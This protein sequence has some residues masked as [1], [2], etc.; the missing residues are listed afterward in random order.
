[1]PGWSMVYGLKP[2]DS[3]LLLLLTSA[4]AVPLLL[5]AST[6]RVAPS[7]VARVATSTARR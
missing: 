1:V 7:P 2:C 4:A 3:Q 5:Q 6:R